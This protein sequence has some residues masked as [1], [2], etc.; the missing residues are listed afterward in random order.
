MAER[1]CGHMKSRQIVCPTSVYLWRVNDI[2]VKL[3][4][5]EKDSLA[6]AQKL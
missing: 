3:S 4:Q 2:S 1:L 6:H 5:E